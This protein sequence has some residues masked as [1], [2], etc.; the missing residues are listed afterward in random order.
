M[1]LETEGARRRQRQ[2]DRAVVVVVRRV[3]VEW[4]CARPLVATC[5]ESTVT[6][7]EEGGARGVGSRT[8]VSNVRTRLNTT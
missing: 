3:V 6:E 4:W 1:L 2:R 5:D 8:P 7:H